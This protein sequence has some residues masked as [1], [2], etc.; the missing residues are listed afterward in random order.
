MFTQ[1]QST[2]NV[3]FREL[4]KI[5]LILVLIEISGKIWPPTISTSPPVQFISLENEIT[6]MQNC[7]KIYRS[8]FEKNITARIKYVFEHWPNVS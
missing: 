3:G 4:E 8:D 5:F 7:V 6:H 1:R 2:P